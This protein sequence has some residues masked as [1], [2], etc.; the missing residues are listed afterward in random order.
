MENINIL[1][2]SEN[3]QEKAASNLKQIWRNQEFTDVTLVS[4]DGFQLQAHKTVLCS[5][6]SSFRDILIEN[7]HHRILLYMR[8]V[9]KKELELLL[10]FTYTGVCQVEPADLKSI[11]RTDEELGYEGLLETAE[12]ETS[13]DGVRALSQQVAQEIQEKE[14]TSTNNLALEVIQDSFQPHL[15]TTQIKKAADTK[16]KNGDLDADN[17]DVLHIDAQAIPGEPVSFGRTLDRTLEETFAAGNQSTDDKEALLET[18]RIC[19]TC[20]KDFR[21]EIGLRRH[22]EQKHNG[23][24]VENDLNCNSCKYTT[25]S[26]DEL[27]KH[28]TAMG[29]LISRLKF[30]CKQC[31]FQADGKQRMLSHM[32]VHDETRYQCDQCHRSYKE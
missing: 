20:L 9:P 32:R 26:S 16:V 1:L 31:P 11:L 8:G 2:A 3:F 18:E 30:K 19:T 5:N 4:S 23:V 10:E 21:D 24:K 22:T 7:Q 28:Q 29:H 13:N 27:L 6:S 17:L 25:I 14:G 12:Q 15:M